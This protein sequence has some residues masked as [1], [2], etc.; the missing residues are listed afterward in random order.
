V[1]KAVLEAIPV[2]KARNNLLP[3]LARIERGAYSFSITR[4]GHP[5]AVVLNFEDYQ[6]MSETLKFREGRDFSQRLNQGLGEARR[7]ELIDID[8]ANYG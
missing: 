6:R 1:V 5:I 8:E 4:H 2:T 3:L 7:G